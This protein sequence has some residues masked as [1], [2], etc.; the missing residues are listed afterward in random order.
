MRSLLVGEGSAAR[1]TRAQDLVSEWLQ[2]LKRLNFSGETHRNYRLTVGRFF[3]MFPDLTLQY[4]SAEHVERFIL[5]DGISPRSAETELMN[6]SSFCKYL[7]K[8]GLL[9]ENPCRKVEKPRYSL[10]LRPAPSWQ[11]FLALRRVCNTIEE[12]TIVETLYFTGM[13]LGEFRRVRLRD[14]DF[15]SRRI[16]VMGKGAKPRMVVFPE[17]VATLL[18]EYLAQGPCRTP[19]DLLFISPWVVATDRG[20]HRLRWWSESGFPSITE[21]LTGEQQLTMRVAGIH[22]ILDMVRR[23]GEDAGLPYRLTTHVL[24]HGFVR[25]MKTKG[26]PVEMTARLAGHSSITTTVKIYGQLSDDDLQTA[27]DRAMVQP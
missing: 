21:A 9:K 11:D 4:L 3:R 22:H 7:V 24:R 15:S 18:K 10:K 25:L 20:T 1:T 26:V 14:V 2:H 12:A 6:L 27:Y 8:R 19:D 13:R 16:A 23:L 5:R 17:R